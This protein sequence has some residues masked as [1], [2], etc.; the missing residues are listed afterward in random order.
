VEMSP[1][2][3][4]EATLQTCHAAMLNLPLAMDEAALAHWQ[5]LTEKYSSLKWIALYSPPYELAKLA[6]EEQRHRLATV[7]KPIRPE[8]LGGALSQLLPA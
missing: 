5:S 3:L 8:Q 4:D 6:P 7:A 2:M 1:E